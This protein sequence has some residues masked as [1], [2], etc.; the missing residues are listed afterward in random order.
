M[1]DTI[2]KLEELLYEII[3]LKENAESEKDYNTITII[4]RQIE[5]ILQEIGNDS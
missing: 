4:E 2:T 1:N 5:K 3:E